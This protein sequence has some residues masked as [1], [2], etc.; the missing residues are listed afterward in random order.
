MIAQGPP[1]S[2]AIVIPTAPLTTVAPITL[3]SRLRKFISRVRR[4]LCTDATE[5]TKKLSDSTANSGP[6]GG[7]P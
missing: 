7:S 1:P 4:A 6:T 2:A 5:V 3:S